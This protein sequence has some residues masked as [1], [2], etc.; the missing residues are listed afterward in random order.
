M[1]FVQNSFSGVFLPNAFTFMKESWRQ[2]SIWRVTDQV[3]LLSWLTYFF[4][5]YCPLIKIRF[6]D[7]S[8]LCFHISD[9]KLVGSF[10][11]KS[12]RWS[13]T[14]VMVDFFMSYCPLFKIHFPD[15]SQLWF[16]ISEWKLVSSNSNC[17][18]LKKYTKIMVADLNLLG[19]VGDLYCFSN[20]LSMLVQIILW[21]TWIHLFAEGHL[22]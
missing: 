12:Y 16:H 6:R 19:S 13:W 4:M 17:Y 10:H 14:F 5:S 18:L 3:R 7:F 8:S 20:T 9:W 1:P 21:F 11:M 15:F 2:A 22:F